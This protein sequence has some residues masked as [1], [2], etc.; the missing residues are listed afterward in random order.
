M[1]DGLNPL[2]Y[3]VRGFFFALWLGR[4]NASAWVLDTSDYA[5]VIKQGSAASRLETSA[6][7]IGCK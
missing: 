6:C 1:L 4:E 2:A 7:S 3:S 5:E